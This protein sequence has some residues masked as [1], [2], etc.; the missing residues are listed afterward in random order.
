MWFIHSPQHH[1]KKGL[2]TLDVR[3]L[4]PFFGGVVIHPHT[5]AQKDVRGANLR[6]CHPVV[7]FCYFAA[8]VWSSALLFGGPSCL[9][10]SSTTT[11]RIAVRCRFRSFFARARQSSSDSPGSRCGMLNGITSSFSCGRA[12]PAASRAPY[13]RT[14]TM[15]TYVALKKVL[16][17]F[18]VLE[19]QK[20][21][22]VPFLWVTRFV[23]AGCAWYARHGHDG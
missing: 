15:S 20:R 18:F 3:H 12:F 17:P 22:L 9:A 19:C 10:S 21:D 1:Q 11:G 5:P 13:T 7:C 23:R 8:G 6:P 4:V 2:S 14:L 16:S